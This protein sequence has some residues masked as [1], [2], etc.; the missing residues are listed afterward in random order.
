MAKIEESSPTDHSRKRSSSLTDS[1]SYHLHISHRKTRS[2]KK[3]TNSSSTT[4][5]SKQD[6]S[7][8]PYIT[9]ASSHN[10][11]IEDTQPTKITKS[12][13]AQDLQPPIFETKEN[14]QMH[15]SNKG[16]NQGYNTLGK[17]KPPKD[18]LNRFAEPK[19][20]LTRHSQPELQTTQLGPSYPQ[21]PTFD[22]SVY[23]PPPETISYHYGY[24]FNHYPHYNA[25]PPYQSVEYGDITQGWVP[26]LLE[27]SSRASV[28]ETSSVSSRKEVSSV[29]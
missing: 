1:P 9:R 19:D 5:S 29:R 7:N 25:G 16:S 15:Y 4:D 26:S 18:T 27:Y 28:C 8:R 22:P 23:S 2:R 20:S 6:V 14:I 17:S 13:S 3:H 10:D 12:K 24:P 21:Y 11:V